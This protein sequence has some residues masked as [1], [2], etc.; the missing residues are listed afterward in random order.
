MKRSELFFSFIQ[1]PVDYL[2]IV[3]AALSAFLIRNVPEVL[4]LKPKLYT[5]HF[6]AYLLMVIA[7]APLFILIYALEGL[8]D[9]RVTR[10]FWKEMVRIFLA[11]SIGLVLIIV[12]IFLQRE[13]FSSR[14]VILAAWWLAT[15]YVVIARYFIHLIQKWLLKHRGIGV[16]R[17][18]LIGHNG[19]MN[20]IA[21]SIR[22]D[23]SLGYKIVDQVNSASL[24]VVKTVKQ[25]RGIDEIILCEPSLTEDEQ[26]KLI[27]YCAIHN[28]KYKYIPTSRE[29][30]HYDIGVFNGEPLIEVKNTP[31]DGWG[32]IAKRFL[33]V[34]AA[35]LGI[36]VA[37]PI[38][39]ATAL[40]IKLESDGP[41][42]YRNERIGDDGRKFFVYKFRYFK[43]EYCISKDNPD[44]KK[45]LA[46]EN[47]LIEKQS[48]RK[49]PLYKIKNDPRKTRVGAFI[50]KYS[51]DEL[52]QFFNVLFG[53]MSIVGPRPHQKREVEK[54][55]EYHR[56][57]L[58][59]RPGITGMAQISGRSDLD[60]E[61]EYRL[62]LYYI[63][64]WSIWLDFQILFKTF[65][66]LF[67]KRR[68]S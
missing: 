68:N 17:V 48:V 18:L 2:M 4:L 38:M 56:R 21:K 10:K 57:L 26:E 42:I 65:G 24:K 49:G 63:E 50:E 39:L 52:P 59:I 61:K 62:D 67:G 44:L 16:H 58:T 28:V 20:F 55:M 36:V 32:R 60:F 12:A 53:S 27:D 14:F 34:V 64:N 47:K 22:R 46:L 3:L 13:W 25:D 33:D 40:A 43:N 8:Y 66:V 30:T 5:F 23:K 54:Y 7:I 19:K 1:V 29:T 11:T 35:A 6:H 31:L 37:S 45:A 15:L 41:V 51:I 9:I